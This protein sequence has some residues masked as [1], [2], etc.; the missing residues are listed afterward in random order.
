M[1]DNI[2]IE[3][4]AFEYEFEEPFGEF[5]NESETGFGEFDLT[6]PSACPP[7][8][9]NVDCPNPGKTPAVV[10]DN[11]GFDNSGFV[12]TRHGPQLDAFVR[13]IVA[14]LSSGAPVETILIAGHT[15][16][17]GSDDYNFQL[18]W[19]RA[20]IVLAELCRRLEAAKRGSTGK[21]KF[22]LTSCGERQTKATAPA[23]RRAE[24]F[25]SSRA[26]K[27][28][29]DNDACGVPRRSRQAE[30]EFERTIGEREF[31]TRPAGVRLQP[32]LCFFQEASNTSHR[33]HFHHQALGTARR[34]AAIAGP[35]P[36]DCKLK[37]GATPYQ[38]GAD[39]IDA[40]RAAHKCLGGRTPLRTIH[41][42]GHSGYYG[43][44]GSVGGTQ[45]LYQNSF[46]LDDASRQGGGRSIADIPTDILAGDVIFVLHGCNQASGCEQ[47]ADDDNF[48]KSLLEHLAG[49]LKNPRVF[50]HYNFGCAG[51]NNSW[52][53]YSKTSP[54]GRANLGP[55]YSE[56]G[57]CTPVKREFEF[58]WESDQEGAT[59]WL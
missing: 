9:A 54:K 12:T 19:R 44:F 23:S 27:L 29:P 5:G 52:C 7:R 32:K 17:V 58:D 45:G 14:S 18:G 11:F 41:I 35:T 2:L 15:D 40:M 43:I 33:N 59:P 20:R 25:V 31:E 4:E 48:A 1:R 22:E 57:G 6:Q 16:R 47:K 36:A 50:A 42:F 13:S 3:P 10:L 38:T 56:P 53:V 46:S 37:V 30:L 55:D 51:R 8:S 39:I 24:I 28:P 26:R 21:I 49:A 34:I